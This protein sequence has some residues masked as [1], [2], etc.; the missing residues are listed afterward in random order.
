MHWL[1]AFNDKP[2]L[3]DSGKVS[4]E[5]AKQLAHERHDSFEAQRR[6]AEAWT[7]DAEDLKVLEAVAKRGLNIRTQREHSD[8]HKPRTTNEAQAVSF[9]VAGCK[10]HELLPSPAPGLYGLPKTTHP[11]VPNPIF[12]YLAHLSA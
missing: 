10:A 7:A 11:A 12:R 4:N 8:G 6:Q 5:R 3:Q 9:R 1:L 2:I